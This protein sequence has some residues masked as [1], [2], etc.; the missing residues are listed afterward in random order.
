MDDLDSVL[1]F[2][3]KE[4]SDLVATMGRVLSVNGGP[5]HGNNLAVRPA[6]TK[7]AEAESSVMTSRDRKV[8]EDFL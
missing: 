8:N 6:T 4:F 3:A 2:E 7:S 1:N 5:H